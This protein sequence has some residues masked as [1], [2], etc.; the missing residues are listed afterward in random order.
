MRL[1]RIV[2]AQLYKVLLYCIEGAFDNDAIFKYEKSW[3]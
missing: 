1:Y 2:G 3:S